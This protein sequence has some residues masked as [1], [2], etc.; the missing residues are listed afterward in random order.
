MGM[1]VEFEIQYEENASERKTVADEMHE[2][3]VE[4]R[5]CENAE[6]SPTTSRRKAETNEAMFHPEKTDDGIENEDPPEKTNKS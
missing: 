2:I 3:C 4:K 5:H 6:K 1:I